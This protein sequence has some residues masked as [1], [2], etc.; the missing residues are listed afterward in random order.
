MRTQNIVNP[1]QKK[2]KILCFGI[3]QV[4]LVRLSDV[5]NSFK[6]ALDF[7]STAFV[8]RNRVAIPCFSI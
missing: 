7:S 6:A 8:W 4:S 5:G 1:V 3:E 2:S